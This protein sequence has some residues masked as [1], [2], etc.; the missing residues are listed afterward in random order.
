MAMAAV[1]SPTNDHAVRFR[2]KLTLS[3]EEG[4]L[5]ARSVAFASS[6]PVSACPPPAERYWRAPPVQWRKAGRQRK[7]RCGGQVEEQIG[8]DIYIYVGRAG[9]REGHI[10]E[11]IVVVERIALCRR[12]KN[13]L[14]PSLRMRLWTAT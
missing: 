10:A 2:R 5:G 9:L 12:R 8:V 1:T 13:T 11:D 7:R 6:S 14:R 4:R 3:Q